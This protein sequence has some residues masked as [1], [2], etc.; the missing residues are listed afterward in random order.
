M[1]DKRVSVAGKNAD[2][3]DY[4][5]VTLLQSVRDV[6]STVRVEELP[7]ASWPTDTIC[8]H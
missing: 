6:S 1:L 3:D 5:R 2:R 4:F 7:L 8:P